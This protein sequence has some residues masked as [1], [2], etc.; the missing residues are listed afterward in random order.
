MFPERFKK[1]I[2]DQ[3]NLDSEALLNALSEPSPVSIR[4]NGLKW[5]LKPLDAEKVSWCSNGYYLSGRP[6]YTL[7]PLF[8]SGCYYPQE[9]SSMFLEQAIIQTGGIMENIRVL[10]LCG[11]P[12][13]KSTHL[14]ELV[15]SAG[16]LVANEVIRSRASILAETITKFGLGNS[17]VTNNDPSVFGRMAGYF[18]IILVDAPCSGEGMFRNSV[19]VAE[20][21][22]E[23]TAHC[24]ERQKRI[25]M[26]IW[27]GL[28]EN[29]ILIYST[30][31]FNPGENEENI[32]WLTERN[33][34]ECIRLDTSLFNGITEIDF[35]GIYGYGFY[36]HK[37][38]GE[39]FFISV[40][41]KKAGKDSKYYSDHHLSQL[42]PDKS[43]V[44]V[45]MAWTDFKAERILKWG[46]QIIALPCDMGTYAHL[47]RNLKVVKAG[48]LI[49]ARKKNDMIPSHELALSTRIKRDAFPTVPISLDK[50]V[51]FLHRDSIIF[52]DIP[53]GWNIITYEDVILGFIKNL[54]NR[55]NNYFPVEWRIRIDPSSIKQPNPVR[56]ERGFF[57]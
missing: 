23:N 2:F 7:D 33:E 35:N 44:D 11:A 1:R 8:H 12:G 5:N 42:R 49:A 47:Y 43:E 3:N 39:G 57:T 41:R 24:S 22:V 9:A 21:S 48:T 55:I 19:A 14:S 52:N 45:A 26:D 34:A 17:L 53:K 15:G 32:K 20:W 37:V 16:F 56:W 51:S 27:P 38:R 54:G 31:T 13:G 30:C 6:T 46:E 28:K 10:D 50:A 40:V 25:I 29:G 4:T 18:D 36:P